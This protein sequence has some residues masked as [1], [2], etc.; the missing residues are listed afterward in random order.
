MNIEL[1][2]GMK[3][4]NLNLR[5]H[6]LTDFAITG[7]TA[8][9]LLLDLAR[10]DPR[11][12]TADGFNV[13]TD[14]PFHDND[15]RDS[16]PPLPPKGSCHHQW[17]LKRNQCDIPEDN[18]YRPSAATSWRLASYCAQC[19]SHLDLKII[20]PD[21]KMTL[22]PCPIRDRPLH[23]FLHQPEVSTSRQE[24]SKIQTGHGFA[25]VDIQCFKCTSPLCLATVVIEFKPPRLNADWIT[26]LTDRYVI[27]TRAEKTMAQDPERY[28]GI[29]VPAPANVI[30][31]LSLYIEDAM[32]HPERSKRIK[33]ENKRFATCFGDECSELLESLGFAKEEEFWIP[34]K[35]DPD[36]KTPYRDPTRMLLDDVKQELQVLL[37]KES[38]FHFEL[39]EK[40]MKAAL[41][42]TEYKQTPR[43]RTV[44]LTIDEHPFYAG[45]GAAGDFHDELLG[46]AYDCQ[47]ACD[48]QN[49]P[50]YLEC[51]QTIAVGRDNS[52]DLQTKAIIEETEGRVSLK[53]IRQAYLRLGLNMRDTQLADDTIIGTFQARVAD[54]PRHEAE[55]RKDLKIIGQDR[56]SERIQLVASQGQSTNIR[57]QWD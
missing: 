42:C 24:L 40:E 16:E 19:G 11:K 1:R 7:K 13:L 50:Y 52:E 33:R 4:E 5:D 18:N 37:A 9:R 41:A 3:P 17:V 28:E 31:N 22:M 6:V 26:Q 53:D 29:A 20:F 39:A 47:I 25:W 38:I 14:I 44:D 48:P 36:P 34:P 2:G 12:P 8:P 23:H 27:K 54:A 43:A 49:I 32:F 57:S 56:S 51:L 35:P 15:Q 10:Y 45:L 55:M 21:S 46:F 30:E